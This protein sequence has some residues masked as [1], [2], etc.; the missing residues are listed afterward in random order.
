MLQ[1]LNNLAAGN[2]SLSSNIKTSLV[3]QITTDFKIRQLWTHEEAAWTSKTSSNYSM[4]QFLKLNQN[5]TTMAVTGSLLKDH[6]TY[7]GA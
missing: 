1:N 5:L 7:S 6:I 4:L 2:E 3:L